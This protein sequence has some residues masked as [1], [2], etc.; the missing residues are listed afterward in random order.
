MEYIPY[1]Q[2]IYWYYYINVKHKD[3]CQKTDQC[4]M[5]LKHCFR[6]C[7][8]PFLWKTRKVPETVKIPISIYIIAT[9]FSCRITSDNYLKSLWSKDILKTLRV[10]FIELETANEHM[11]IFSRLK[12]IS[13]DNP[14]SSL[15]KTA[16]NECSGCGNIFFFQKFQNAH[17]RQRFGMS[18]ART[19]PRIFMRI[20]QVNLSLLLSCY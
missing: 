16:Y 6:T 8:K 7:S 11:Y 10:Y 13:K 17:F 20:K 14:V 18:L 1:D 15:Q 5:S 4:Y 2:D 9:S 12:T 3:I 19:R